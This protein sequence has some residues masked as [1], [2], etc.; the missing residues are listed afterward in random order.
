MKDAR[1]EILLKVSLGEITPEAAARQLDGIEPESAPEAVR[2]EVAPASDLLRVR[3]VT[4]MG[5]VTVVGDSSVRE[6]IADG[7][8]R[9]HREGETLVIEADDDSRAGFRFGGGR[10]H[11]EDEARRRLRVRMNPALALD[12]DVSAGSLR[13]EGVRGPIRAKTQAG[14][15]RIAEFNGPLDLDVQ[16]GSVNAWGRLTEGAS[17]VRCQAGSVNINLQHGSS[18]R[19]RARTSMGRVNLPDGRSVGRGAHQETVIGDGRAT[20]DIDSEMGSV[21]VIADS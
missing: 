9:A 14:S 15:T 7:P 8:H 3:I 6:A 11:F 16:A 20:L 5:S 13:V 10:R 2:T 21:N 4:R 18:V 1:R 12:S 19:V 17:H